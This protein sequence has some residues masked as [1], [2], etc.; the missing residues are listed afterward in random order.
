MHIPGFAPQCRI[1]CR[2]TDKGHKF[3]DQAPDEGHEFLD[4]A[5]E[6]GHGRRGRHGGGPR[7]SAAE[8][9]GR[10]RI[11]HK[12]HAPS[13]TRT[14]QK[15]DKGYTLTREDKAEIDALHESWRQQDAAKERWIEACMQEQEER[16]RKDSDELKRLRAARMPRKLVAADSVSKPSSQDPGGDDEIDRA[17]SSAWES[18]ADDEI[19]WGVAPESGAGVAPSYPPPPVRGQVWTSSGWRLILAKPPCG[20]GGPPPP[21]PPPQGTQLDVVTERSVPPPPLPPPRRLSERS[22][23]PRPLS[24]PRRAE[25]A[26]LADAVMQNLF[27]IAFFEAFFSPARA[28]RPEEAADPAPRGPGVYLTEAYSSDGRVFEF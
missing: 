5:P 7:S 24:P 18:Q 3:L 9:H 16:R 23:P 14:P 27:E 28:A 25:Q 19:R 8:G 1:Q 11:S 20:G 13:R 12:G 10:R 22:E 26:R 2:A 6:E 15:W 17:S 4:Q 21:P